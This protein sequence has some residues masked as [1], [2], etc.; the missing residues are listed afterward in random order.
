MMSTGIFTIF[1]AIV[2]S[3]TSN[4]A[5]PLYA[6]N[7]NRRLTNEQSIASNHS[8]SRTVFFSGYEWEVTEGIGAPYA[9]DWADKNVWLD[10][11]GNLHLKLSYQNGRWT[12]GQVMTKQKLGFGTYEFHITG[13]I[14]KLDPNVV[15]AM[16]NYEAHSQDAFG[17][18]EIDIEFG[19]WGYTDVQPGSYTVWPIRN[20]HNNLRNR[21]KAYDFKLKLPNSMH[22]FR[23]RPNYVF[24]QSFHGASTA[25]KDEFSS[26]WFQP[27]PY[28]GKSFIPLKP[29]NLYIN[30]WL[31]Q[32]RPPLNGKEVEIVVHSFKYSAR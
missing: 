1:C 23:W 31:Y 26:W 16:F 5:L 13:E 12:G 24:F 9:S 15:F 21:S 32:G 8:S 18:N 19:K 17:I 27:R 2:F 4:F 20:D 30:I 10:A 11:Q 7:T 3:V 28:E 29:L 22:R 6:E 14:D 25:K